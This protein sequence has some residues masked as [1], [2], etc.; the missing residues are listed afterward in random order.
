MIEHTLW[1][2]VALSA[3]VADKPVAAQLLE[4]ALVLWRDAQGAV[5]AWADKC[6]HRGAKLS[7]GRVVHGALGNANSSGNA[8]QSVLECA[9]HGWQFG[10]GIGGASA[11]VLG[12]ALVKPGH[13]TFVP[14]H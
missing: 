3:D 12:A 11:A 10:A 7:L 9:Y 8:A 1:H 5:H 2:P 14:A 4:Q 6:P 13:C